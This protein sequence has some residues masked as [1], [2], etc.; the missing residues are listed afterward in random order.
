MARPAH[1]EAVAAYDVREGKQT[2]SA[3]EKCS[4]EENGRG[5]RIGVYYLTLSI[6]SEK[7]CH[8]SWLRLPLGL[9]P[10]TGRHECFTVQ[11]IL[12]PLVKQNLL[13]QKYIRDPGEV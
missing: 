8:K 7:T 2:I 11:Y 6:H 5:Q 12:T 3:E 4:S 10:F 1:P 13:I 9:G